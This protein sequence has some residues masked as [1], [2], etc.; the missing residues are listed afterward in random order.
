MVI[1]IWA[2]LGMVGWLILHMMQA[3]WRSD[4]RENLKSIQMKTRHS[5]SPPLSP[6]YKNDI[7]KQAIQ[8]V[9]KT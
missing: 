7:E 6:L 1:Y 4:Q 2:R 3:S 5:F 9:E 8:Q